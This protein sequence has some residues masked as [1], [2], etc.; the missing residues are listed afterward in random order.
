MMQNTYYE[1]INKIYEKNIESSVNNT[2]N[3]KINDCILIIN[4][5][6]L[7]FKIKIILL[8]KEIIKEMKIKTILL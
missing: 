7:F 6:S 1:E 4:Y 8:R 3:D 2:E 5:F